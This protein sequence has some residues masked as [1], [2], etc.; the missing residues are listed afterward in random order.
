[1]QVG[2]RRFGTYIHILV[3]KG[4]SCLGINASILVG[5]DWYIYVERDR[6]RF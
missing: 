3:D 1:M 4:T 5:D 2:S 6:A